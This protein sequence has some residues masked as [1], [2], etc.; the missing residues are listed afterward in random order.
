MAVSRG[1]R[2]ASLNVV[3]DAPASTQDVGSTDDLLSEIQ[4][5]VAV[6]T[7]TE[8][9]SGVENIDLAIDLSQKIGETFKITDEKKR[10]LAEEILTARLDKL[11]EN[12]LVE[13]RSVAE[14]RKLLDDEF[15]KIGG[16]FESFEKYDPSEQLRLDDA[17]ALVKRSEAALEHAKSDWY[18]IPGNKERAILRTQSAMD[19]AKV[20]EAQAKEQVHIDRTNRILNANFSETFKGLNQRTEQTL[21]VL[22]SGLKA[23]EP[24]AAVVQSAKLKAF[25]QKSKA[26]AA[27]E[28]LETEVSQA[29]AK[30]QQDETIRDGLEVATEARAD[31]EQQVSVQQKLL[32]DLE[33]RRSQALAVFQSKERS[34]VA[35]G[36]WE[37]TLLGQINVYK[38]NIASLRANADSWKEEFEAREASMKANAATEASEKLDQVGVAVSQKNTEAAAKNYIAALESVTSMVEK[39]PDRFRD[40][41]AVKNIQEQGIEHYVAR[42]NAALEATR[43]RGGAV[44]RQSYVD[45]SANDDAGSK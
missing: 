29:I 26:A 44:E 20:A 37:Q 2:K 1:S 8:G 5:G 41:L 4:S 45:G 23:L 36:V 39:H 35:L 28:K 30:L 38:I 40:Q 9:R 42:M 14:M 33:S 19:A 25:E 24:K 34:T 6:R 22:G 15:N 13:Q 43:R 12:V 31:A 11:R 32:Q 16:G 18:I 21:D 17:S 27:I 7:R 3:A 10:N